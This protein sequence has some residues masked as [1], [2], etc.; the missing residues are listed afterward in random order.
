MDKATVIRG[1]GVNIYYDLCFVSQVGNIEEFALANPRIAFCKRIAT[2][3]D[4][5]HID[6]VK[7]KTCGES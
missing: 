7:I 3:L 2:Y 4:V 6:W 5:L 1:I